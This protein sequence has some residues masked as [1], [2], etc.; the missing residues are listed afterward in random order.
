MELFAKSWT[1][2]KVK[3]CAHGPWPREEV[4]YTAA[5]VD[6]TSEIDVFYHHQR[7]G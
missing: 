6:R 5:K 2:F 4:L 3:K 1:F 7:L